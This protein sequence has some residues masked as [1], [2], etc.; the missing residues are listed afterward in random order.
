[1]V[2]I[3]KLKLIMFYKGNLLSVESRSNETDVGIITGSYTNNYIMVMVIVF[4]VIHTW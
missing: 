4:V 1:M 3:I 2:I